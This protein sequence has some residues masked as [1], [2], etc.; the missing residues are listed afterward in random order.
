MRGLARRR[1]DVERRKRWVERE[2]WGGRLSPSYVDPFGY[3]TPWRMDR[4][5]EERRKRMVGLL[6][7]TPKTC[8]NWCCGNERKHGGTLPRQWQRALD[9]ANEKLRE[10]F[11]ERG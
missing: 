4:W 11:D 8:S 5:G 10:F 2:F 3:L 6:S 9:E 1:H 7:Q